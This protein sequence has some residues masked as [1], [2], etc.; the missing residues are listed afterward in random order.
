LSAP[1]S[2]GQWS[3]QIGFVLAAA[4][5][6]IGLGNIWRFPYV[7]GE[8]G[9]GAFVL[10]Y[11]ICVLFIGLPVMMLEIS[12]GRATEKNPVGAFR[13]V[14]KKSIWTVAA[15]MALVTGLGILSYYS[16]IAGKVVA[17]FFSYTKAMFVGGSTA[18]GE[19]P[20]ALVG[21]LAVFVGLTLLVV[22]GGVKSGIERWSKILMPLL[23]FIMGCVI[24]R[25]LFLPNAMEGVLWFITPDFSKING[26]IILKAMAQAFFSLSLG[27]GAMITYGSYLSKKQDILRCASWVVVFDTGIAIAAGFMIFPA[28]FALGQ[29]PKVGPPL[30]FEV[31][32][33]VFAK[34]PGGMIVGAVFFFLLTVAAL[35]STV[36]LLEVVTAYFVDERGWTRLRSVLVVGIAAVIVGIPSALSLTGVATWADM[37]AFGQTGFLSLMDFIFGNLALALFSLVLCLFSI[38][39]WKLKNPVEEIASTSPLFRKLGTVWK[40]FIMVICPVSIIL[41]LAQ[42]LGIYQLI[43][44]N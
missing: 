7:A 12:I 25:G 5:S 33:A 30:I 2:R 27:M 14:R 35:T 15:Y 1:S 9:G 28:V 36:S 32:P 10:V 18:G 39:V 11:L 34:M 3:S 19:T 20:L 42:L 41:I 26:E 21:F 6:A 43:G 22:V 37:A 38:F 24:V 31:L 8:S 29:S 4:G 44:L 16:V 23:L 17:Y 13:A 40:V